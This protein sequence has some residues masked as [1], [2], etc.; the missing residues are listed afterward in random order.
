MKRWI[1][2]SAT[3]LFCGQSTFTSVGYGRAGLIVD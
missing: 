2:G 1:F 3:V